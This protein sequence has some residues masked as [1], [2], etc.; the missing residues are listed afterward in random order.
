[1]EKFLTDDTEIIIVD[2]G[3]K[4]PLKYEGP[5]PVKILR[6]EWP[7]RK[8]TAS[9]ARNRGAKIAVGEYLLMFDLDHIINKD[10]LDMVRTF[11]GYKVQFKREAGVLLEDGT[12]SQDPET[13]FTWGYPRSRYEV[14]GLAISPHPNMFAMRR[15]IFW[16][17][18]GYREDVILNKI[19]PQGEDSL[20]KRVWQSKVD[21]GIYHV[22]TERP[23]IYTFP[24]GKLCGDVDF[25]PFGLFHNSSRATPRNQFYRKQI[26]KHGH[27]RDIHF[28]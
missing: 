20:F 10:L 12:L 11:G 19:Y 6:L 28:S 3:S 15:E 23:T 16:E 27:N 8:W 14:R 13:L 1:M 25:N 17:L 5:L 21:A 18:G 7:E 4:V 22:H 24:M 26:E 2:D 9:L